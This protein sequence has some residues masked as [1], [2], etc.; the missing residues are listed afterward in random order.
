[1]HYENVE[2]GFQYNHWYFNDFVRQDLHKKG[3]DVY[4]QPGPAGVFEDKGYLV[5]EYE[6]EMYSYHGNVTYSDAAHKPI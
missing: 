2:I 6:W 5:S 3:R 4:K 1:M